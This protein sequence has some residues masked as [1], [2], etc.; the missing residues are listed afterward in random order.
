MAQTDTAAGAKIFATNCS[1]CHGSDGRGGERA[2]NIATSRNITSL[3]DK[4]LS[5]I[6]R[7]GV[8]GSGMPSFSFFEDNGIANVVAYLRVL[9]GKTSNSAITGNPAAGRELFFGYAEC[10]N[11]HMVHGEGGYIASDLTDFASGISPEN[12][13]KAIIQAPEVVPAGSQRVDIVTATGHPISGVLR[14]EDNFDIVILTR[15]GR[16]NRYAKSTLRKLSYTGQSLMP[17]DYK[18][19]L[20]PNQIDDIIGYLMLSASSIEP[21]NRRQKRRPE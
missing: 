5:N 10:S 12:F 18:T 7:T 2:P 9:Q 19:R 6:I 3:S 16:F 17:T 4:D 8:T 21:V 20:S 15:D 1:G 11:C 14:S 13:R